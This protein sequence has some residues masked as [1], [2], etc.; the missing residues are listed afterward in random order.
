M[1]QTDFCISGGLHTGIRVLAGLL[2]AVAISG[3]A[4]LERL[5]AVTYAEARQIDILDTPDARFYVSDTNRI[6][7]VAIKAF[8]RSNRARPAQ[9]RNFI[10]LSGG[11]D[12]GAFGAGL[13]VG[14]SAHGNRPE[15]DM[16]TGVS[17]GALSA[18]FVFLGRAYDQSLA[19]M[20]TETNAGDIFQ[21]RPMLI[22]AVTSDSLVDNTPLRKLI[23][24]NVDTAM[25][26]RI[27][28]E[29]GK[30]RLLFVLTT[31]L[32]QSRPV[33]WNIGAIAATNNPK[34][35]D[36]IIDVLLASA[37]I[38]AVFPP[39]ML[40][41]TVDGQKRQEM[42]VDG[43]TVAQVFFYPPSFS[44]RGAAARLGVDAQKLRE[45]K[46]VA[47]VIRNGRFFR[48]DESV[49]LRTIAIAKEALSTMTMS[50]GI[51][52]TYRMYALA[53]RDGVDFNLASI[54]EDFTVPYKGPFDP[55]YMQALFA[56]GYEKGR[57]GYPWKKVPPGYTN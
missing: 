51:N 49:Q 5:P 11:G 19:A 1:P 45:R 18:P 48:P 31:N 41:V 29:Y 53:R 43:G 17:T 28:E 52:D 34:A 10:A 22:A 9:T 38:P 20:Y 13:M 47:Y 30:G 12:D 21:R 15:F 44:I 36:L 7:D 56:Y 55:G 14:W 35:R 40:D 2:A 24:S 8:Q 6:Y 33:I 39:V 25:V 42:H 27:A 37:S 16:V 23:E 50:S 46:R 32:D 57:A 4:T 26:Q 3:C 54:G